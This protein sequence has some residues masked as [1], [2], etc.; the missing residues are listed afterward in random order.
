MATKKAKR[1]SQ[2]KVFIGVII[3]IFMV[4]SIA[5]IVLYRADNTPAAGQNKATLTLSGKPYVFETKIE[6]SGSPYYSVT[7]G[8]SLPFKV[9]FLPQQLSS[10]K[11]SDE[12]QSLVMDSAFYYVSFDPE[13]PA[14]NYLDFIRFEVR[15]N[16]PAGRYFVDAVTQESESYNLPVMGCDNSTAEAPVII[17][18][19]NTNATQINQTGNCL[20]ISFAQYDMFRVRDSL[21]YLSRGIEVK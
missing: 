21:I 18:G 13:D 14:I 9:Y 2:N 17:L 16:L 5:G 1:E 15:N 19:V 12:S 7:E 8:S 10:L 3:T 11:M 20:K 6:T 4:S